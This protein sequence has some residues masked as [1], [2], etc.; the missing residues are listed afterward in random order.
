MHGGQGVHN[1]VAVWRDAAPRNSTSLASPAIAP[2]ARAGVNLPRP[3]TLPKSR[4]R[5]FIP[6]RESCQ[7]L[8]ES[9]CVACLD[10]ATIAA[11]IAKTLSFST[12]CLPSHALSL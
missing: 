12:A 3:E 11:P 8:V 6:T 9:S 7:S 2:V 4:P 1:Q 10:A 5:S